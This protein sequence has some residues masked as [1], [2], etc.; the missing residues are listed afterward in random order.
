[1]VCPRRSQL[2]WKS[3]RRWLRGTHFHSSSQR[4]VHSVWR[5]AFRA[6]PRGGAAPR[7]VASPCRA[8][9]RQPR[10]VLSEF[11]EMMISKSIATR[12]QRLRAKGF[13][14]EQAAEISGRGGEVAAEVNAAATQQLAQGDGDGSDDD[15]DAGADADAA[16]RAYRAARIAELLG[17]AGGP[18]RVAVTK[19]TGGGRRRRRAGSSS[20]RPEPRTGGLRPGAVRRARRCARGRALVRRA[21]L[22]DR[23][24]R[25][26]PAVAAGQAPRPLLLPRRR[27]VPLVDGRGGRRRRAL[28]ARPR[29]HAGGIG[30]ARAR[31]RRRRRGLGPRVGR[32][33]Q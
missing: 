31:R 13:T 1:M 5:C 29:A 23:R 32:S 18:R 12:E 6:E 33:R 9:R 30:R 27:A 4:I 3:R 24:A 10:P 14:A 19:S 11:D 26:D 7:K 2:S 15:D 22:P 20:R 21:L 8:S 17:G 16:L 25:R 28:R